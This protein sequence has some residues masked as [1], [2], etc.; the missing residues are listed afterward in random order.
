MTLAPK[1]MDAEPLFSENLE[2]CIE[3]NRQ[4]CKKNRQVK[5]ERADGGYLGT[6]RRRRT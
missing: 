3:K 2:N 1:K 4:N 5:Q 6:Q